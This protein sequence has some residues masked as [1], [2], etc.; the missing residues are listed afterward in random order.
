MRLSFLGLLALAA[1]AGTQ[2]QPG[3]APAPQGHTL[4]QWT[5]AD[6]RVS[7]I[8][9]DSAADVDGVN[10]QLVRDMPHDVA[11]PARID[12]IPPPPFPPPQSAR[13]K[14][15][16][17]TFILDERGKIERITLTALDDRGYTRDV[18]ARLRQTRFTPALKADGTPTRSVWVLK[19][20]L[21]RTI[22]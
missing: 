19:M 20:N 14:S 2:T 10:R 11:T 21:P 12:R 17:A 6:N 22:P 1:C 5:A 13:G 16:T 4:M 3:P 15:Y 9:L 18:M 7:W 8:V